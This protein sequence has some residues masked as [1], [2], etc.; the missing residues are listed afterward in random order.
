MH[1]FFLSFSF[2]SLLTFPFQKVMCLFFTKSL[3]SQK[4]KIMKWK[5][6]S[7]HSSQTKQNKSYYFMIISA[8]L[9]PP[10]A[11]LRKHH[12]LPNQAEYPNQNDFIQKML[13][14]WRLV[15]HADRNEPE[16]ISDITQPLSLSPWLM[17][18]PGTAAVL[19]LSRCCVAVATDHNTRLNIATSR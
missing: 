17:L 15:W 1:S 5:L 8:S 3:L 10:S 2:Y 18:T 4:I 9:I 13:T 6:M 7:L 19:Q 12:I 11:S 16:R 14:V